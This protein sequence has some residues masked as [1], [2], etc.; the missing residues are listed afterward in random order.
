M[1]AAGCVLVAAAGHYHL[2][3]V[4]AAGDGVRCESHDI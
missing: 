1:A 2:P 3:L 4:A